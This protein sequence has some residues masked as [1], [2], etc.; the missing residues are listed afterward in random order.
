MYITSSSLGSYV[1]L[2]PLLFPDHQGSTDLCLLH[3]L[4]HK[5]QIHY[6]AIYP[7][8]NKTLVQITTCCLQLLLGMELFWPLQYVL[9]LD[10]I[11]RK[12]SGKFL[13]LVAYY[14]LYQVEF[15]V[16]LVGI[17]FIWFIAE[18]TGTQFWYGPYQHVQFSVLALILEHHKKVSQLSLP[19]F[20]FLISKCP[21]T[22]FRIWIVSWVIY[23]NTYLEVVV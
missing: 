15:V 6:Q 7:A 22:Q 5:Q 18:N 8:K 3:H 17:V 1:E 11:Y 23:L 14:M 10:N 9:F 16:R 4:I 19:H 13:W 21:M 2:I 12:W 20:L